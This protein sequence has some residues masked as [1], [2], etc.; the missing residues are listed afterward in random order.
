MGCNDFKFKLSEC[1]LVGWVKKE[2][3]LRSH[4][5]LIILGSFPKVPKTEARGHESQES[6]VGRP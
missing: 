1:H 6:P 4:G 5:A 3:P 2:A